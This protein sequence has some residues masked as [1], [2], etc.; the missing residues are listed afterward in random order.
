MLPRFCWILVVMFLSMALGPVA[1]AQNYRSDQVDNSLKSSRQI[2]IRFAKAPSTDPADVEKFQKFFKQYYFPAMTQATPEGL[3]ELGSMRNDLFKKFITVSTGP[4]Q[5]FLSDTAY[6]WARAKVAGPYHPAVRYNALLILGRIDNEY[7]GPGVATP[8]PKPE[9]NAMLYTIGNTVL[10]SEDRDRYPQYLLVGSL[11]GMERH[12]RYLDKL[13]NQQRTQTVRLLGM[14][15]MNGPQG[16]YEPEIRDWVFLKAAQ[17]LANTKTVG[18]RSAFLRAITKRLADETVG[19]DARVEMAAMLKELKLQAG[20]DG[21]SEAVKEVKELAFEVAKR[22]NEFA[23]KFEYMS[24]GGGSDQ[25]AAGRSDINSRISIDEDGEYTLIRNSTL[26]PLL[27]I[28]K[29][30][31]IVEAVADD[32]QKT[33]ISKIKQAYSD[34]VDQVANEKVG[35]LNASY[36]I[37]LMYKNIEDLM[38]VEAEADGAVDAFTVAE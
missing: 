13:P 2:M 1:C 29:A 17:G 6:S 35:D 11:I 5:R 22:E 37:K 20:V 9:A 8:T 19:L 32:A 23:T 27:K 24:E 7:A 26:N 25:L 14:T 30:L 3:E 12:A 16:S 15:L 34:A 18:P 28:K 21:A 33:D 31:E 10:R 36:A 38:P 4:T